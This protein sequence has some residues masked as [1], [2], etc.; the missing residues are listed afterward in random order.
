MERPQISLT[1][2]GAWGRPARCRALAG[3]YHGLL[4]A[5]CGLAVLFASACARPDWVETNPDIAARARGEPQAFLTDVFRQWEDLQGMVGSYR[6]RVSR[7]L[8]SRTLDTQIFVLRDGFFEL[9]VLSPAAT[10]EGY[11]VAGRTEIGFWA[12][13]EGRLYRGPLESGAFGR[14]LGI[15]LEPEDVVAVLL[16]FGVAWQGGNRPRAEWDE[17]ERR[18]RVSN[19]SGA[20]AFLHP[21][22]A[23]FERVSFSTSQGRIE[24]AFEEWATEPAPLPT[25]LTIRVPDE[26]I[27]IEMRLAQ[28]WQANPDGLNPEYFDVRSPGGG[29]VEVPLELLA[30]EGGLL[31]RGLEQ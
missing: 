18:I 9:D 31:R 13:E 8:G 24:V 29:V 16:G 4:A 6:V 11:L 22:L 7:G 20:E 27:S 17:A 23:R 25:R 2:P 21:V 28:R 12:N 30:L 15:D 14:A 10:T 1:K 3:R 19:D 26:D 5:L